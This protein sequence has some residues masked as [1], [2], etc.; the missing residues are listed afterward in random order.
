MLPGIFMGALLV[1]VGV[2][3]VLGVRASIRAKK[4]RDAGL[5]DWAVQAGLVHEDKGDKDFR[6]AWS[7]LPEIPNQGEIHHL[8]YG[9]IDGTSVTLFRHRYVVS[10]GQT[11]MVIIH[12]V[13]SSD[14]PDWPELHLRKRSG[15]AKMLGARSNVASDAAF[16]RHWVIKAKN[17]GFAAAMLRPHVMQLLSPTAHGTSPRQH[18]LASKRLRGWHLLQGKLCAVYRGGMQPQDLDAAVGN[19]IAVR[20]AIANEQQANQLIGSET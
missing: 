11:T 2:F 3:I 16:D 7:V 20:E 8:M 19:L 6:K 18:R 4:A 10:T 14:I 15:F 12:W 1:V 9:E 5:A 17:P 13:I